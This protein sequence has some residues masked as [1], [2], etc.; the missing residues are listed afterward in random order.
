MIITVIYGCVCC[1]GIMAYIK[2][3]TNKE[4]RT[5]GY[6]VEGYRKDGKVKQRI[7]H[8]YSLLDEMEATELGI[9]ERLK[10][11]TKAG[12]LS[13]NQI[14]QVTYDLLEPMNEPD[15]S[16]VWMVLDNLF[17]KLKFPDFMKNVKTKS[18]YDLSTAL[19]LL[20]F[21]Q[22]LNPDSKLVTVESQVELFGD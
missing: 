1:N 13:S 9:L 14:I 3:T 17:E 21:Q 8:K 10:K 4:G 19:K 12:F 5:H 20:V 11:E 18:N 22:I 2:T 16:Y 15:K 6:L 7:I